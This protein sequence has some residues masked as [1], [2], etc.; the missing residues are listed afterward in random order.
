MD[1]VESEISRLID[2]PIQMVCNVARHTL[3]A[4]GK[5]LRPILTILSAKA[6]GQINPQVITL[7]SLIELA[8]TASLI[9]DDVID[10]A[11]TR[12]GSESANMVWGNEATVLVGD[13]IISQIILA[14]SSPDFIRFQPL[15]AAAAQR[16]CVGQLLEIQY[17]RKVNGSEEEY[18][19]LIR[20]KTADLISVACQLGAMGVRASECEAQ[21]L[22]DYG[23]NMGLAFQ[24]IDDLLDITSNG[25]KLGKPVGNDLREGKVTL[26]YIR[27]LA[28]AKPADQERLAYL[29]SDPEPSEEAIKEAFGLV[30][31]YDG[32][33][34]SRQVAYGYAQAARLSLCSLPASGVKDMLLSAPDFVITRDM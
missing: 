2:S 31:S 27:T 9:H 10:K 32:L 7:A 4:G 12:R 15:V 11:E 24:I 8:H 6:V 33:A 5:R 28:V 3:G 21:A 30:H 34:Y 1:E 17:R 26:P 25:T 13:Y 18:R 16:M 19:Q 23:M 20:Y 14:L 22:A 29:L